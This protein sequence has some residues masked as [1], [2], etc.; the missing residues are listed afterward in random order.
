MSLLIETNVYILKFLPWDCF[1]RLS[2][3]DL[4]SNSDSSLERRIAP[5]LLGVVGAFGIALCVS[6]TLSYSFVLMYS[7]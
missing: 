2:C 3:F 5:T 6:N 4:L 7:P 1:S